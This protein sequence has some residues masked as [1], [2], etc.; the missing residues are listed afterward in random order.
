[1]LTYLSC[2]GFCSVLADVLQEHVQGKR[3]VMLI[4]YSLGALVIWSALKELARRDRAGIVDTVILVAA[5]IP[6]ADLEMWE[7]V[8]AVVA[9]RVVNC[10]SDDDWVLAVL[11]RIHSL[12]ADIAGLAPVA[13]PRVENMD[14]SKIVN[15]HQEYKNH[16]EAILKLVGID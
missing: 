8:T 2:T 14:V 12:T 6:A 10:W 4:G 15:G 9:R 16:M 5:P 11:H 13:H 1:M 7:E 3:P